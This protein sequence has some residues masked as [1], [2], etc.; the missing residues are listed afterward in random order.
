M[1]LELVGHLVS[2]NGQEVAPRTWFQ[3]YPDPQS[4][5]EI[6]LVLERGTYANTDDPGIGIPFYM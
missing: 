5:K 2:I 3:E 4:I 1:V 6:Q